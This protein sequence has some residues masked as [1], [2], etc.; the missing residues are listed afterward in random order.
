VSSIPDRIRELLARGP[1][2]TQ[3]LPGMQAQVRPPALPAGLPTD[4]DPALFG[5]LGS[6]QTPFGAV[7]VS[8]FTSQFQPPAAEQAPPPRVSYAPIQ[9]TAPQ[10]TQAAPQQAAS[11][12]RPTTAG[13]GIAGLFGRAAGFAGGGASSGVRRLQQYR[14]G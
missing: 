6:I 14:R 4:L 9:T 12:F 7:D 2:Q 10:Y 11:G 8:R 13:S 1:R 3:P 5:G